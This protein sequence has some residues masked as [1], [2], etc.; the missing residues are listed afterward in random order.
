MQVVNVQAELREGQPMMAPEGK[1]FEVRKADGSVELYSGIKTHEPTG[2]YILTYDTGHTEVVDGERAE[3][4]RQK[5]LGSFAA[6]QAAA[7]AQAQRG[8]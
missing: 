3:R 1:A 8:A 6:A 5:L 2:R 7:F 4:E